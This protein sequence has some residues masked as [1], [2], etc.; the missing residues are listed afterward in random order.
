MQK[1]ILL[2]FILLLSV[3]C[4]RSGPDPSIKTGDGKIVGG[5]MIFDI[6]ARSRL[7]DN[8]GNSY[9]DK[10]HYSMLVQAKDKEGMPL[11]I[12]DGLEY[13]MFEND[14]KTALEESKVVFNQDPRSTKNQIL[15][16]LDFSGSVISECASVYV[17]GD[18]LDNLCYQLVESVKLFIDSSVNE[19]QTMAIYYFNSKTTITPLVTSNTAST[20][21]NILQLKQGIEQLYDA[22]FREENLAGYD[23]TNLY[24]AVIEASKV[25]CHWIGNCNYDIYTP[26]IQANK[27]NFDF[28]SVVVFT[29]GR[30]LANRVSE[31]SMLNF[32]EKHKANYYYTIGLGNV[33]KRVL[34]KIGKD[35]YIPV[36]KNGDLNH[37]FEELGSELSAWGH[38]FYKVDYCPA[39]QE[40]TVDILIK[41]HNDSYKGE[42]E[43][44]ITLPENIDFRCDL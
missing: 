30:D 9:V 39:S 27:E 32:I 4:D 19:S 23:S 3:G 1:H 17:G 28:A 7:V 38:S 8:S 10:G 22:T 15:L 12:L 6:K 36:D 26:Q 29:D 34:K 25:A 11:S 41:A 5:D 37:A 44:R 42:I 2:I 31:Q 35:K 20:T 24:G 18:N 33:D 14:S 13:S 43:D 40:G 21:D 16:L